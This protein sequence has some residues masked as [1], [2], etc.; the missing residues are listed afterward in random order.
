MK[1]GIT[2][3]RLFTIGIPIAIAAA[4]LTGTLALG[5]SNNNNN[6]PNGN[7]NLIGSNNNGAEAAGGS[8]CLPTSLASI[9]LASD[10]VVRQPTSLPKGYMLQGVMDEQPRDI[11]LLYADHSLCKFPSG[12]DYH[13]NQL[14]IVVG[15]PGGP[16]NSTKYQQDW[17]RN[18][19]DPRYGIVAKVQPIDVN[20]NKG[21]GWE[22]FDTFSTVRLN[23]TVIH[24][25]PFHGQAAVFFVNDKDQMTYSIFAN[26]NQ[27]LTELLDVARSI[28]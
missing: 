24:S 17:I 15:K 16:V 9:K 11:Q 3:T 13:G 8:P 26:S 4:I 7:N 25:E 20:G 14:K 6:V 18:A 28:R 5:L 23:G 10:F 21:A 1:S 27:T 12:L 22:P 19:A 2:T